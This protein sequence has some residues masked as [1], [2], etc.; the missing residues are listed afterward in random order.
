MKKSDRIRELARQLCPESAEGRDPRYAGYIACFNA[1]R[2]YDAHDVL[3]DLWLA[4][5]G[6]D[7]AFYKGLIQFAGAFVHL[8]KHHA[9]PTHPKDGRRLGPASRLFALAAQNLVPFAPRHLG[10]DVDAV[11]ALAHTHATALAASGFSSNSWHPDHA[12]TLT[13]S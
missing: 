3:E 1:A 11:L 10:L 2:Y 8:Q 12:P 6:A 4:E 9:R 5:P 7:A 13:L